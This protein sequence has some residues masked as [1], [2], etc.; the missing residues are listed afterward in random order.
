MARCRTLANL[1]IAT[2]VTCVSHNIFKECKERLT[3]S[4]FSTASRGRRQYILHRTSEDCRRRGTFG[5]SGQP[6]LCDFCA[7]NKHFT[8]RD[9]R[10]VDPWCWSK[11]H[12][13]NDLS[14][15]LDPSHLLDLHVLHHLCQISRYRHRPCSIRWYILGWHTMDSIRLDWKRLGRTK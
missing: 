14:L 1:L 11:T 13:R 7:F 2:S 6:C 10:E 4:R 5:K 9:N 12:H 3:Y 8:T 15:D